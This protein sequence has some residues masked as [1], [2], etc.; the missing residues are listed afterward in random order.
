M[1]PSDFLN[2]SWAPAAAESQQAQ[3]RDWHLSRVQQ[4]ICGHKGSIEADL[5]SKEQNFHW[6]ANNLS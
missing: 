1:A 5:D 2:F 3:L 4:R 6:T